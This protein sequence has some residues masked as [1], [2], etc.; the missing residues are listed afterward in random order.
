M[1]SIFFASLLTFS[2]L[3]QA[4]PSAC[5][6]YI[7]NDSG[8][9]T[10]QSSCDGA[11]MTTMFI[12]DSITSAESKGIPTFLAQGYSLNGCTDSYSPGENNAA[13]TAYSRCIFTKN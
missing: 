13:G 9:V 6:M 11:E 3:A 4:A 2:A 8:S 7:E 12:G 10:A 1:K 5:V